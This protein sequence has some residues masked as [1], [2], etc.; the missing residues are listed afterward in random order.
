MSRKKNEQMDIIEGMLRNGW[1]AKDIYKQTNLPRSTV[2][3]K[4]S[5]LKR[6]ARYDF[7]KV[8]NEDYLWLYQM[9]LMNYSRTIKEVNEE[10]E[11]VNKKYD[12]LEK[13]TME[14]LQ[15]VEERKHLG[16]SNFISNLITINNCRANDLAKLTQQRDRASEMKARL[17]NQG[18]VA[19]RTAEYLKITMNSTREILPILEKQ[20]KQ[21]NVISVVDMKELP[22]LDSMSEEDKEILKEMENDELD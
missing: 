6:E 8:I 21:L 18:P 4:V 1:E 14:A 17:F 15:A 10:I 11:R 20:K 16:K 13:I 3:A 7:D 2:Y 22:V 5:K 19:H 12:E 9:N